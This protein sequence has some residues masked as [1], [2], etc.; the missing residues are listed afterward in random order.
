MY[1]KTAVLVGR[2]GNFIFRQYGLSLQTLSSSSFSFS[3]SSYLS[4]F[5]FLFCN[6]CVCVYV[7]VGF[8]MCG[9]VYVWI[10]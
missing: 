9:Y 2:E 8:V 1:R 5:S 4:L 6:L 7:C 10:L 3:S